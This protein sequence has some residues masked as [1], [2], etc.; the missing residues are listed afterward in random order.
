MAAPIT[1]AVTNM[2]GAVDELDYNLAV[3]E[4]CLDAGTIA[5]VGDGAT[6]DKYKIGIQAISEFEGMGVPIFKPR[7]DNEEIITRIHA[8]EKARAI[9]VGMDIDAVVFKTMAMKNQAVCAKSPAELK[10]L[11][12]STQIPFVLKG[13]M[14]VRDAILA[15]ESGAHAI[16]ISNHGG[17]VLDEMAGTMD[18]LEEIVDEVKGHVRIIIDGGFRTGVDILKA[19][20]LGA[21]YVLIGRPIAFAAIGMGARGVSFYLENLKRELG[22]AMILTGCKDIA[23]ITS[24]VVRKI[25]EKR[26]VLL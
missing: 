10:Y 19:L 5:F 6:P 7:A 2:G 22:K 25:H 13:I 3:V 9:A 26:G 16:V 17:R 21:D 23:D 4:G 12:S 1:G 11:S 14:N 15:V 8:A 24:D 20:A 18:V